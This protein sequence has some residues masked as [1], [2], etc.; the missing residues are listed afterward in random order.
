MKKALVMAVLGMAMGMPHVLAQPDSNG[1][2][3]GRADDSQD[4]MGVM[5]D[6]TTP[7]AGPC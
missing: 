1:M 6:D 4:G 7:P 3:N 5:P 2:V